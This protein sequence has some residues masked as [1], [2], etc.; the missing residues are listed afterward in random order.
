MFKSIKNMMYMVS[1]VLSWIPL[2]TKDVMKTIE[3][4]PRMKH[5]C[6]KKPM[7]LVSISYW[8]GILENWV[9]KYKN[10]LQQLLLSRDR[11]IWQCASLES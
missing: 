9:F 3:N 4:N 2:G 1:T 5:I 8:L 7:N 10:S 11:I 6:N